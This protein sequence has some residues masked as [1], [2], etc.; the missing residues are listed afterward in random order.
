MQDSH[1]AQVDRCYVWDKSLARGRSDH[2]WHFGV[3]LPGWRDCPL[4]RIS[5]Y[6]LESLMM[7]FVAYS[8]EISKKIHPGQLDK[9]RNIS[10]GLAQFAGP[11]RRRVWV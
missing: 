2:R 4:S 3:R 5:V 1:C 7:T 10:E 8:H 11:E 6:V 9:Y